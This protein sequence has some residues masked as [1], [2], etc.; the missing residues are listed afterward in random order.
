MSLLLRLTLLSSGSSFTT[1][2]VPPPSP[3]SAPSSNI[4]CYVDPTAGTVLNVG[5][6]TQ[7]ACTAGGTP[8]VIPTAGKFVTRIEM[9]IDKE[10][11][12][13]GRL[14]FYVADKVNAKPRVHTCGFAGGDAIPL[15]PAGNIM[16]SLPIG[17]QPLTALRRRRLQ[18][19]PKVAVNPELVNPVVAAAADVAAAAAANGG[20]PPPVTMV[21]TGVV[22]ASSFAVPAGLLSPT[23][24]AF[25]DSADALPTPPLTTPADIV[26]GQAAVTVTR[27]TAKWAINAA[28]LT[29]AGSG[30]DPTPANNVVSFFSRSSQNP[31]FSTP[32]TVLAATPTQ[33][34]VRLNTAPSTPGAL[35][36]VVS[37]NGVSSG[38]PVQ[39]ASMTFAPAVTTNSR[40][41]GLTAPTLVISGSDFGVPASDNAVVFNLGAVGTVTSGTANELTVTFSTLPSS[42]GNLTAIVSAYGGSSGVPV[43]VAT[44]VPSPTVN[45]N[46]TR[47]PE[48]TELLTIT[49]T[50]F[51]VDGPNTVMFNTGQSNR[52]V[53]ATSTSLDVGFDRFLSG[54]GNLTAVVTSNGAT[55]GEPVQVADV[56]TRPLN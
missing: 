7:G 31:F 19:A 55:S 35:T 54:I 41:R 15:F 11:P 25:I 17:C 29:I 30:F 51:D 49:G 44:V 53:A 1:A 5:Q 52:V 56:Y 14:V 47:I 2:P 40:N 27:N 9:A 3:S 10:L 38:T 18:A 28:N 45:L 46:T 43:K 8:V 33:L 4:V 36:A 13:V 6:G 50:G 32:G 20:A 12:L 26:L 34:I 16:T 48:T 24:E 39:V 23:E 37:V 22:K 42:L 21:A